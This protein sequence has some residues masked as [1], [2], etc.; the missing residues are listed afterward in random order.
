MRR[1]GAIA[2]SGPR[3]ADANAD[4]AASRRAGNPRGIPP[5]ARVAR[6]TGREG[7]K[8]RSDDDA[9][10]R[11]SPRPGTSSSSP[12]ADP[13][14]VRVRVR[15][16]ALGGVLARARRSLRGGSGGPRPPQRRDGPVRSR[17]QDVVIA[18]AE[19][20]LYRTGSSSG[21]TS[22]ST[23]HVRVSGSKCMGR[24]GSRSHPPSAAQLP[25]ACRRC[26]R[27]SRNV[28]HSR[29][30]RTRPPAA[31]RASAAT[32]DSRASAP[33]PGRV[34]FE[35]V[36][37]SSRGDRRSSRRDDDVPERRASGRDFR[38]ATEIPRVVDL[39]AVGRAVLI[40]AESD[41]R[42][43]EVRGVREGVPTN[44]VHV[45]VHDGVSVL[46]RTGE[47]TRHVTRPQELIVAHVLRR[48]G[49]GGEGERVR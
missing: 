21:A 33:V 9:R 46:E 17:L 10:A 40:A 31:S 48:D 39:H 16:R 2:P 4:D 22:R 47:H 24:R 32:R 42:P 20:V 43:A 44:H 11:P 14:R 19:R 37:E 15:A 12:I 7:E 18:A 23:C 3:G 36:V 25:V 28:R 45:R 34:R 27:R 49:Q 29:R 35:P 26:P 13:A 1:E 6:A 38:G 8:S 41:V 5:P 30:S